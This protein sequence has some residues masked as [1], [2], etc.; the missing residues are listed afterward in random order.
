MASPSARQRQARRQTAATRSV[1][2][3]GEVLLGGREL[4][5]EDA[6]PAAAALAAAAARQ[7]H[8]GGR[9]GVGQLRSPWH[10]ED[11]PAGLEADARGAHGSNRRV[12]TGRDPR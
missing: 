10:L 6:H 5:F 4:A 3:E 12:F 2:E 1:S 7:L 9:E 8:A 11:E